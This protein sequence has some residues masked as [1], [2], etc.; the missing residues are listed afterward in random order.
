M[1]VVRKLREKAWLMAILT[2]DSEA[3]ARETAKIVGTDGLYFSLPP[4]EK[5]SVMRGIRKERG[6]TVFVGDGINDAPVLAGANAGC[7]IG[8]S[9]TDAAGEA[10]DPLCF[11]LKPSTLREGRC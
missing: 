4:E 8:L 10:A 7:T 2:G 1:E 5:L 3:S 6:V 9:S 11:F